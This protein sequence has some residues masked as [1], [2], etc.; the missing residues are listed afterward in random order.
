MEKLLTPEQLS[1]SL[2]VKLSTIY[3]WTHKKL[4]P[5]AANIRLLRFRESEV[6][7]WLASK[8]SGSVLEK[9]EPHSKFKAKRGIAAKANHNI[10]D[11]VAM[12]KKEV[13]R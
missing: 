11:I 9:P 13:L 6:L 4:I 1:E 8:R 12:A 10:D 2:G 7:E 5:R 3:S